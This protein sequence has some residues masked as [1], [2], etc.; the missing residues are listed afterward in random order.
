M[1]LAFTYMPI[2]KWKQAE[3]IALREASANSRQALL[4]L[5]AL[6]PVV[7][8]QQETMR[9]ALSTYVIQCTKAF[10]KIGFDRHPVAID[11]AM[12]YT[13]SPKPV[14]LLVGLCNHFKK[15]G[16]QVVPVIDPAV[17]VSEPAEIA[18][19][20]SFQDV[21]LRIRIDSVT[22]SQVTALIDGAQNAINS[23]RARFHV[24]LD[25][26]ELVGSDPVG[27]TAHA[28]AYVRAAAASRHGHSVTLA[29]GSF[30]HTLAGIRQGTSFLPRVEW[31]VWNS[32]RTNSDFRNL[33][34]GDYA[35]T[36]PRPLEPIDPRQMNPSVAVRYARSTNW[37]L[38]KAGGS[39]TSGM[40][41]Y[42]QVCKLLVRHQSYCGPAFSYGDKQY[43]KHS[44]AGSTSGSY[45]TWRR[46]ATSHHL[47]F[48]VKQLNG[49]SVPGAS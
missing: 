25:M 46:D 33:C 15:N 18:R 29:G 44:Q 8:K 47:E 13:G 2:L 21:V 31:D 1:T 19:L 34:F 16:I 38:I 36:N 28:V 49:A 37:M 11:S 24:L 22:S 17:V 6:Q 26:W 12:T 27:V 4:P 48:T 45:M 14:R 10:L 43:D 20:A 35:V 5:I 39:R 3:Q 32:I 23:S 40:A 41:Q 9:D 42:N 7:P 30:P